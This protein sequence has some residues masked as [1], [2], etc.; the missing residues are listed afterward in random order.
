VGLH[1]HLILLV[2]C[3][4]GSARWA[5][6]AGAADG[7]ISPDR[8][9]G[10]IVSVQGRVEVRSDPGA[11]WRLARPDE[12][13]CSRAVLQV[14]DRSRA[15]IALANAPVS[16]DQNTT[17]HLVGEPELVRAAEDEPALIRLLQGAL[18]VFSRAPHALTVRTPFVDAGIEGTEFLV[19]VEAGQAQVSVFEGVVAARNP[20]GEVR[21]GS[22]QS[23]VAE[24]GKAPVPVVVARPRDAV[25][26][27]LHYPSVLPPLTDPEAAADLPEAV[28]EALLIAGRGDLAQAFARL[29]RMPEVERG[30]Q[31]HLHRAALL[32][33]VGRVDEARADI[34]GALLQDPAAG[35]AYALRTLIAVAQNDKAQALADARRAVELNPRQ[36]APKIAF[37]YAQQAHFELEAARDALLQ[38]VEDEPKNALA[39]ARLSELW[40]MLGYR[41]RARE[42][43]ETATALAPQLERIQT[44]LGF[45]ALAEFR[46][47]AAKGAFERAIALNS[48][49][50]L[51]RFGLGLAKIRGGNL[52]EGRQDIEIAVGL[53]PNNALLRSYL[54]KAYF[55][56]RTTN[57]L[58]YFKE[59][60]SNFPN[61][62]NK[63]AAG[64]FAIAKELDPLDPTPYFY[65]AIRKQ[66][67]NRPVEALRDAEKAIE[68]NENR[69]VFRSRELLDQ[70]RAARG[71]SLGRIYNDLGFQQL[72][73]NEAAKALALDPASPSA[74]RFLSD[75]YAFGP[76]QRRE[77][78]R[79]SELLQAQ[80]LQD[81]NIN[82]VQPSLAETNLNVFAR[83]GPT[84][85][86]FNEFTPLFERNQ[87]Q[88]N[89]SGEAGSNDTLAD[90]V[91]VSGLYNR[92][93]AS[94]GQFHYETDGFR[95]N[96]D[97]NHDFYDIF[98]QAALTPDISVQAELMR[99]HTKEGDL[100]LLFDPDVFAELRR[101]DLEQHTERV[102]ARFSPSPQSTIIASLVHSDVKESVIPF[103]FDNE[104]LQGETQYLFNGNNFNLSA[105]FSAYDVNGSASQ[106]PPLPELTSERDINHKVGYAYSNVEFPTDVI[107]SFGASVDHYNENDLETTKLNPKLG[108]Q[109]DVTDWLRLRLTAFETTKPASPVRRTVQPTQIAGFN[110]IFDDAGGTESQGYGAGIDARLTD[111]LSLGVEILRRNLEEPIFII[112]QNTR[113]REDREE[114]LF[115]AYMYWTLNSLWALSTEVQF[116]G[117]DGNPDRQDLQVG[118]RRNEVSTWSVPVSIRYFHP[119]GLFGAVAA[120]FVHQDVDTVLV[121]NNASDFIVADLA[122]GYRFPQG[123]GF[124]SFETIN[125]FDEKFKF[126]WGFY[127]PNNREL[128]T[129]SP[130]IPERTFTVRLT[131]SF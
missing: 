44:V 21:V 69:A 62:E 102:G 74:H 54:G 121:P 60:V 5:E 61:Q 112:S 18:Y 108:V 63:L 79:V 49:D 77:I 67:E 110:Q 55:E 113:V 97:V 98:A 104:V 34:D 93:S 48:A 37:S 114:I 76:F 45:A 42:A 107:W 100:R 14:G 43:A 22:G 122:L 15:R 12:T 70:D 41:G 50:P 82:P 23:V 83:G 10:W 68:L 127:R 78:A 38:A 58:T 19:R 27:A 103:S 11:S 109:W 129:I 101:R 13:L 95:P 91:V 118:S 106:L 94:A 80:L 92:F 17:L 2:V 84:R 90:E 24:A 96:N 28:Q 30:A 72:G 31:F 56:E 6:P 3:L 36:A 51:P 32:L 125:L 88:L 73:V 46:T 75:L 99:R 89:L 40:L 120:T 1:R 7:C 59:L 117:Y 47:R 8:P 105:G 64:Q 20:Y 123:R 116:D 52:E 66:S 71:A 131:L 111:D 119:T 35:L 115:Q 130:F 39:W 57:P 33:S 29:D 16:L 25:A 53:D 87:V 9:V 26:W 65:D 124:L 86:G 4:F 81:I 126:A 85:P 128:P